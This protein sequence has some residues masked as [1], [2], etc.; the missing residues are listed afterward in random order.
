[1]PQLGHLER[2]SVG[3]ALKYRL[4]KH[5]CAAWDLCAKCWRR[6]DPNAKIQETARRPQETN[7]TQNKFSIRNNIQKKKKEKKIVV[8][9]LIA[10]E[11]VPFMCLMSSTLNPLGTKIIYKP[12]DSAQLEK[13][14]NHSFPKLKCL[15]GKGVFDKIPSTNQD[16]DFCFVKMGIMKTTKDTAK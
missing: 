6:E 10:F 3:L 9:G 15:K 2:T 11:D 14:I 8:R 13:V 7:E 16:S 5:S 12:M 4:Q 1:M